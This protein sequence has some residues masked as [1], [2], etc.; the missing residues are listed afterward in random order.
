LVDRETF[1]RRLAKLEELLRD[2]RALAIVE[3]AAF[4]AD[5]STRVQAERWLQLA[6]EVAIDLAN[7]L[8]AERGWTTPQ[9]Y[10]ES[11]R[12]LAREGVL[13][14]QLA[15]QMEGWAALRNILVHLYLDVDYERLHEILKEDLD[16]LESFAGAVAEQLDRE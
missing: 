6:G 1:D 4:L 11:F 2:L 10:R 3:R 7:Q 12:I 9:T 8:I 5:R 16:Q 13:A 14:E 15:S